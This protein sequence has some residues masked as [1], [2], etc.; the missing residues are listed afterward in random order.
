MQRASAKGPMSTTLVQSTHPVNQREVDPR[1]EAASSSPL[2]LQWSVWSLGDASLSLC[3]VCRLPDEEKNR[4]GETQVLLHPPPQREAGKASLEQREPDRARPKKSGVVGRAAI[5]FS[6]HTVFWHCTSL[7]SRYFTLLIISAP[8]SL[9]LSSLF[10]A[11]Q[12]RS[13]SPV[14]GHSGS[15]SCSI[16]IV[17]GR[18]ST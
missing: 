1:P 18:S 8:L 14:V 12:S 15:C 9:S 3:P 16:F 5:L 2:L 17:R 4:L 13:L 6:P 10:T 11:A 7:S